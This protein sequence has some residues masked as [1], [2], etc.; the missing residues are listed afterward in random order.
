MKICVPTENDKG[1]DS[2]VYGHFGSAPFFAVTDTETDH[3]EVITNR[4]RRHRHGECS[5]AERIGSRGIEAVVCGGMGKRAFQSLAGA[6]IDVFLS[7]AETVRE[8]VSA[9]RDNKVRRLTAESACGGRGH[10]HHGQHGSQDHHGHHGSHG[11]H[12]G[13]PVSEPGGGSRRREGRR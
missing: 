2:T 6:G 1:L 9:V 12:C 8:A 4:E 13:P 11:H 7:D 5:P 3:V 10:Q